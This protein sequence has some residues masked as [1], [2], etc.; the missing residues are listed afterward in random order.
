LKLSEVKA[1]DYDAVFYPGGHGPLWDL[2]KDAK[3]IALL[4]AFQQQG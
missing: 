2:T 4:E 1:A 3:S